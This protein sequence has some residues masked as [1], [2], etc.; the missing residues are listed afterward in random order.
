M[1]FE[2]RQIHFL[3]LGLLC[4][5]QLSSA[6]E[7]TPSDVNPDIAAQVKPSVVYLIVSR[8]CDGVTFYDGKKKMKPQPSFASSGSAFFI[9][10]EGYLVTNAHVVNPDVRF[11][12]LVDYS[13]SYPR[14]KSKP[15]PGSKSFK[16]LA[17][18]DAY[19]ETRIKGK[20]KLAVVVMPGT[21]QQQLIDATTLFI[22][23][24]ADIAVIKV[25]GKQTFPALALGDSDAVKEQQP[26]I[27]FGFPFGLKLAA[28]QESVRTITFPQLDTADGRIRTAE[29]NAKTG[30]VERIRHN[31]EIAPGSSGGPLVNDK[32]EV[33]G[34]NSAGVG[35]AAINY[36][37]PSNVITALLKKWK[38]PLEQR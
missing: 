26:I 24:D 27:A 7:T 20:A 9:S 8:Q 37:V 16:K 3:L 12:L 25:E 34:V 36:A 1:R 11:D 31:A 21:P 19:G 30:K 32:G 14:F 28:P 10:S 23:E 17:H 2:L 22:D 33:I 38:V 15:A 18:K 4:S 5:L 6:E 29:V 13:M 35:V